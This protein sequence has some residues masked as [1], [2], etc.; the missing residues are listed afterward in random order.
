METNRIVQVVS[1]AITLERRRAEIQISEARGEWR[2]VVAVVRFARLFGYAHDLNQLSRGRATYS[3][4]FVRYQ[5]RDSFTDE[6][7]RDS[8]VGAPRRP[9]VPSRE[10]AV[11]LPEPDE[12]DDPDEDWL[13]PRS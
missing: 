9:I 6:G 11:S 7:D 2:S 12:D 1:I 5:Q 4:H 10:S 13:Q 3:L 8:M